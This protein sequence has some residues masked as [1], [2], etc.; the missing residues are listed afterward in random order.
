LV[1]VVQGAFYII[2]SFNQTREQLR[3]FDVYQ[4]SY[5]LPSWLL[6]WLAGWLTLALDLMK[7]KNNFVLFTKSAKS[8]NRQY[9][10]K[11]KKLS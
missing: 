6:V 4:T 8:K 1:A 10:V 2:K 5:L 11:L 9:S 7:M 3:F